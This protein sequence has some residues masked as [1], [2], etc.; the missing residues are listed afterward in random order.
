[1]TAVLVVGVVLGLVIARPAAAQDAGLLFGR[2]TAESEPV[3]GAEVLLLRADVARH[4]V[5]T[6]S[7][8]AFRVS[9]V[10]PGEYTLTVRALGFRERSIR[11]IRIVPGAARVVDVTLE[12]APVELESLEVVGQRVQISREDTEFSVEVAEE[13]IMLLPTTYDPKDLV[14]LTPGARAGQV[15][16]GANVQANNYQLDGLAANHPGVGGDLVQPSINWIERIEV[17]GLGAGAEYGNFQGGLI[18]IV[19]KT[20]SNVFE[21][22][23][24]MSME[25]HVLNS[26]NLVP[27]EIGSEIA[28]RYDAEAEVRGPVFRDRLFYYLA[29][30]FIRRDARAQNHLPG[31]EAPF[32][33]TLEEHQETKFFSKLTWTPTETDLV[34]VAAGRLDIDAERYGMTGYETPEALWRYEAPTTFYTLSW[35]RDWTDWLELEA[36]VNHFGRVETRSPYGGTDVPG[37]QFYRLRPPF[38]TFLNA[39]LRFHHAPE[40]TAGSLVW[41]L[42][43]RVGG[44]EHVLKLGAEHNR[45]AFLDQR[46]RNGGMTWQPVRSTRV[47]PSDPTTWRPDRPNFIPVTFGGEVDLNA[48]VESSALFAQ[49]SIALGSHLVLTPGVRYGRWLG[50]LTPGG[51]S[52]ETFD[53]VDDAAVE[54]RIGLLFDPTGRNTFV[55]KGHWGRYHQNMIAQIFERVQG[56]NV[57]TNEELWFYRGPKFEDPTMRFTEQER[58]Q[59]AEQG[60]FQ[61]QSTIVLNETGPVQNY[62][63][64]YVD[65]WIVGLEKTFGRSVKL[66][67]VYVNR[68][69][70]N[71]VALVDLNRATNYTRFDR[72]R[73]L[74]AGGN[75]VPFEG[76]NL[77]LREVYIPNFV[78]IER[79]RCLVFADCPDALPVP[80]LSYADTLSLTWD[81]DYVLTTAPDAQ[82]KFDQY[83]FSVEV[84]RPRW[85]ATFSAVF[86]DLRGTLDNVTG[87]DD[88]AEYSAGP[89][90]RVNEGVNSFGPLRNFAERELK[91]SV[92]GQ[93][94]WAFKGGAFWTYAAGDHF[95]PRFTISSIGLNRYQIHRGPEL[96][97]QF[98]WPLEG[99][100]VFVGP[101]GLPTLRRRAILDLH[102]E[103]EVPGFFENVVVS[104]DL[105]NVANSDA[106]TRV[107]TSVNEG[108]NYF[109]FLPPVPGVDRNEYYRAVLERVRPR[110]LRLGLRV[111]L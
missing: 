54:P 13:E 16:G 83:Q 7:S 58:D 25:S 36:K 96:D 43:P 53:A 40:S 103:R 70:R 23:F 60:I 17:R 18:N 4:Q 79:L 86:T 100:N 8:G 30:Q 10:A 98:F 39:P 27:T 88:P 63:Q 62:Q 20:G 48:Q 22:A 74:D 47:V 78:L 6:D 5:A 107:N 76:G 85:G 19:T 81:P 84:Q 68:R 66:E 59:L 93:L 21:S 50:R 26:S 106:I 24:R 28:A 42:R 73:V 9:G 49:S 64:P 3:A 101:R 45:G 99:H 29:G 33:A 92:Y 46:F 94:P 102:L 61:H 56:G 37:M 2:V 110:T 109:D 105:F 108:R 89:Y 35:Q 80:G 72:V 69:N 38:T 90:V 67:A 87:Y 55:L 52:G 51:G 31:E 65:Q 32:L 12:S 11:G 111:D 77:E 104:F 97:Y 34:E 75:P 91:L 95:S 44:Y 57:F 41:T 82:R 1:M 71:M 15:W 14:A